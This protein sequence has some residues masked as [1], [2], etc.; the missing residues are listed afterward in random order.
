MQLNAIL[1]TDL[2]KQNKEAVGSASRL[3]HCCQL[4]DK[5]SHHISQ[6][7]WNF[8]HY[9]RSVIY[10]FHCSCGHPERCSAEPWLGNIHD[11][12]SLHRL[13]FYAPVLFSH[14]N[15]RLQYLQDV[16][17]SI[18]NQIRIRRALPPEDGD[19]STILNVLGSFRIRLE[20][21]KHLSYLYKK[22]M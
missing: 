14:H 2:P 8:L 12:S 6:D 19:S 9:F 20:M 18:L 22:M 4:P 1:N 17:A 3:L 10:L 16:W 21:S 15:L 5:I 11:G 7:I 13:Y